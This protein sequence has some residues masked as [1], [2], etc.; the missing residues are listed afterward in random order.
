[1]SVPETFAGTGEA[2]IAQ[3]LHRSARDIILAELAVA[4]SLILFIIYCMLA[5]RRVPVIAMLSTG[6]S[7]VGWLDH[8]CSREFLLFAT[9]RNIPKVN[10]ET[11]LSF[12]FSLC[13]VRALAAC[14]SYT[15]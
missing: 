5:E 9:R 10:Q 11:P 7:R 2:V 14:Q 13:D 3:A 15:V 1:L 12:L 4:T 6:V 8:T